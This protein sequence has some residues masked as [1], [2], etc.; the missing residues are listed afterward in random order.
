LNTDYSVERPWKYSQD[1]QSANKI[2]L[3]VFD[4]KIKAFG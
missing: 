1:S 2:R 4:E 3:L